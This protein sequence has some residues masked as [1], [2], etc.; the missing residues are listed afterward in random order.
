[1]GDNTTDGVALV[2]SELEWRAFDALPPR[3]R[4]VLAFAPYDYGVSICKARSTEDWLAYIFAD[5][6]RCILG[7][8]GRDHP[9][10]G[11]RTPER[12]PAKAR[13]R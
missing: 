9:Q 11:S 3:T 13:A 8:Y 6:D 4:F 1:M 7:T 12:R 10:I 5:R 2:N